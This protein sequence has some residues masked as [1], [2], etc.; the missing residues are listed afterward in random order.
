METLLLL[1]DLN[2]KFRL[3]ECWLNKYGFY[4]HSDRDYA[5]GFSCKEEAVKYCYENYFKLIIQ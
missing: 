3:V 4:S 2:G 5:N 1:S